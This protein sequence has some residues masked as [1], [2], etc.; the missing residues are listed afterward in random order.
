MIHGRR[1][2]VVALAPA[3]VTAVASAGA[4]CG[5]GTPPSVSPSNDAGAL[6]ADAG[7]Q[8][9]A[10]S[11]LA[12]LDALAAR[13]PTDAPLMR[14]L[15]RIERAG[16]AFSLG[17]APRDQCVRAVFDAPRAVRAWFVDD[18]G[19]TRGEPASG[20]SGTIPPRGPACA[21]KG[22]A[23]RLIVEGADDLRAVVF[24]SP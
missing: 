10:S 13:G 7:A 23:L 17:A 16:A 3:V 9:D 11:A 14:E 2:F 20:R 1:A 8:R 5:G 6:A 15:V 19:A 4:G 18:A 24:A 22:E 21:R 12:E